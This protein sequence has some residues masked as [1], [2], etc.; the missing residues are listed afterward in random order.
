M[1]D[2]S[3]TNSMI[4]Y[5]KQEKVAYI[6]FNRPKANA[7]NL[8]FYS[9]F[10]DVVQQAN[11]DDSV[12]A[13]IINSSSEKFFCAGADIKEFA[14]NSTEEN[15]LMVEKARATMAAI[16]ASDKI[17]IAQVAGHALG[18]GMEII[19]ACD[20]RYA[21]TGNYLLGLP[22]TKLGLMPGNGGTQRLSRLVGMSR[23]IEILATGD[24][25]SVVQA[26][27]W[28]LINQLLTPETLVQE[29]LSYATKV[30][31]GPLK[32]L[33]AT[34]KAIRIGGEKSLADGLIIEQQLC[35][36]LYET[37]DA[38][39]GFNAFLEK[40]DPVFIGK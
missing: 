14:S 19:M 17:Y 27:K 40:R 23:A 30:A 3:P 18:G 16:E 39:E 11:N 28:G 4:I 25:F 24:N 9:E 6:T 20:I 29:T 37:S 5:T 32:A 35:D 22:E 7:Y 10:Y 15:Q 21:A 12:G 26:E 2:Q 13:I 34:K 33:A 38:K 36:T 1:S 31:N 8:A